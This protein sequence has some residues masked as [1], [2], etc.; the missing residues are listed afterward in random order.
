MDD[1]PATGDTR[2]LLEAAAAMGTDRKET[3]REEEALLKVEA[4]TLAAGVEDA[5][6]VTCGRAGVGVEVGCRVRGYYASW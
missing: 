3:K 1:R 6:E 4:N 2:W 5:C